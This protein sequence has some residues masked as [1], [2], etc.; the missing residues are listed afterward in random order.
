MEQELPEKSL[1]MVRPSEERIPMQ[2]V[3]EAKLMRMM[4]FLENDAFP[5][6]AGGER[7]T[8]SS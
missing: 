4:H 1:L 6:K 2:I 3:Q 8:E 5:W 7:S